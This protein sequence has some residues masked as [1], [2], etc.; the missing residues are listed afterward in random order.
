[1][2]IVYNL[3]GTEFEWN[4]EKAEANIVKHGISFEESAEVF[5]DPFYQT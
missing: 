2:D 3:Q 1:M 4:S 5:F